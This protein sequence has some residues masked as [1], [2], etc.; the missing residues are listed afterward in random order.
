MEFS[1]GKREG[2]KIREIHIEKAS[3]LSP[4]QKARH[5][6]KGLIQKVCSEPGEEAETT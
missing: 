4:V 6:Q 1:N 2:E 3:K 5:Q